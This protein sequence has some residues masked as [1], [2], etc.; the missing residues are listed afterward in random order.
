MIYPRVAFVAQALLL[1]A[2]T[3]SGQDFSY[4][5]FSNMTGLTVNANAGQAGSVLRLTPSTNTQRGSCFYNLPTQVAAGFTCTFTFRID[6]PTGGGAD[7]MAFVIHNAAKGLNAIGDNGSGMG[8]AI[9]SSQSIENSL[10]VE[11]DTW[12]SSLGDPGN[13]HVSIHTRGT[14][15]NDYSEDFS[16]GNAVVPAAMDDGAVHTAL[17]G[18]DGVTIEVYV[19]D[20]VTPLISVP[21]DFATGGTYLV[22]GSVGGLNLMSG[23]TAHVGFSAAT[24]GAAETHDVLS[25]YWSVGDGPVGTGYCS[26]ANINSSGLSA[27]ITGWGK[28]SVVANSL[29]LTAS[30]MPVNE[31]GYFLCAQTQGFKPNPGSSQGNL[32]LGKKIGRFSKQL[33]SSGSTGTFTIK[34][35]LNALPVWRNQSV[36]PGET[37]HFQAWFKDGTSSNFSDGLSVLFQ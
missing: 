20:L 2:G 37:W 30:A 23:G 34:V 21:W 9:N 32:C 22:G 29:D 17:I 26:P 8:Y 33:Q 11:F 13:N 1:L 14:A 12:D 28:T 5:D 19:D 36:L 6:L 3:G 7:G 27:T 31:F 10:V 25:W 4:P 18:Y 35:D 24:G 15:P 16:I